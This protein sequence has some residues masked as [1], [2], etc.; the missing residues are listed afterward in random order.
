VTLIGYLH[1]R[2]DPAKVSKS[3]A[4]AAV[5]KAEG[6][7]LVYFSPG[8]VDWESETIQGLCYDEGRWVERVT[9]FPDVIYN[10]AGYHSEKSEQTVR[11]LRAR[12]PFTSSGLG[13]KMYVHDKILRA[14]L[15]DQYLIPSTQVRKVRDVWALLDQY[16][17]DFIFKPIWGRQGVG[18]VY[19]QQ[20]L[21]K[22]L[23]CLQEGATKRQV[24]AEEF[25]AF[26][27]ERLEAETHLI[28]RY[29]CSKTQ[30]G[31]AYDFR[32]HVQKNGDARWE[33]LSIYPRIA[34]PGQI[35]SNISNGGYTNYLTPFL[36]QEYGEEWFEM[37][38][39]LERFS[40][41]FAQHLDEI[42]RESFDELGIDVGVDENRKLWLYEV[43][44]KPGA[45]P[46]FYLELDVVKNTVRY[47]V[48]LAN[49]HKGL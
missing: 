33:V 44:W 35:V 3:Y 42:Y 37:K 40:L 26:L 23:F 31:A 46:A 1:Y 49:K 15:F 10:E 4:L 8:R 18:V 39:Y 36:Q 9:R 2:K 45:P 28:Q 22:E 30:A 12:I 41:S 5:A 21:P 34:A 16:A 6:A 20:L 48:Y 38:R 14:G 17:D 25:R 13:D 24:D 19:V 11:K 43:N 32:L 29:I 7:E 27:A 47:A